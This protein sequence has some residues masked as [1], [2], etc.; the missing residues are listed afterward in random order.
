MLFRCVEVSRACCGGRARFWCYQLALISDPY[1]PYLVPCHLI[2]SGFNFSYCLWL[3]PVLPD[4][5]LSCYPVILWSCD[6]VILF[7]WCVR[8]SGVS[9]CI[10]VSADC[11]YLPKQ[12]PSV[13]VWFFK[14]FYCIYLYNKKLI[15]LTIII[16]YE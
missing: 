4:S 9:S 12:S 1:V 10:W 11:S 16:I 15:I 7:S 2:I 5:L 3:D 6:P 8:Y 14:A 13:L